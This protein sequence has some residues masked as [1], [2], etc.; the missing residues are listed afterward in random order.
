MRSHLVAQ[1]GGRCWGTFIYVMVYTTINI[2]RIE[3]WQELQTLRHFKCVH[4]TFAFAAR[5]RPE[6]TG[7]KWLS[8]VHTETSAQQYIANKQ[9]FH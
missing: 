8:D 7:F 6:F 4:G 5:A 1:I 3:F 9:H 2:N